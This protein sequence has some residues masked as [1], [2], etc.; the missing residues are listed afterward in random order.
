[1]IGAVSTGRWIVRGAD[2]GISDIIAPD[3]T[4]VASLGISRQG[5]V[6]A[7]VGRGIVTPYD[8]FGIAW[9]LALAAVAVV[10]GMWRSKERTVGWRSRRG[11]W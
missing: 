1:V 4:I 5:V 11:S 6:V 9:L 8:R 10:A 3:G 7:D 2:T